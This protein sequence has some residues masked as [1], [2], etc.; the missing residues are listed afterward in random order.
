MK[1][2]GA[3]ESRHTS[4]D[5]LRLGILIVVPTAVA[6]FVFFGRPVQHLS[7]PGAREAADVTQTMQDR[8]P[9]PGDSRFNQR[10][11][12]QPR[13]AGPNAATGDATRRLSE[14]EDEG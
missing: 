13:L 5:W 2:V 12:G 8:L 6:A 11:V 10:R 1:T 7:E 14:A 9:A 4:S 3:S